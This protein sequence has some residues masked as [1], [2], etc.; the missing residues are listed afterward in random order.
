VLETREVKEERERERTKEKGQRK[1][2]LDAA[3][4]ASKKR[5]CSMG[6][7]ALL[8]AALSCVAYPYAALIRPQPTHRS[9]SH[10]YVLWQEEERQAIRNKSKNMAVIYVERL[11]SNHAYLIMVNTEFPQNLG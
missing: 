8:S 1:A 11:C 5:V 3:L 7:R 6:L 2:D 9:S 10:S 4:E